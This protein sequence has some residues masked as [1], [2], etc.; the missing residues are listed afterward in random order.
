M[1]SFAD[2]LRQLRHERGLTQEQLAE[3]LDI[4]AASIRRLEVTESLPRKERLVLLSNFFNVSIDYLMGNTDQRNELVYH[5]ESD[6][7]PHVVNEP[8]YEYQT[9]PLLER[10][11]FD[12]FL[13]ATKEEKE[14]IIA[15]WHDEVKKRRKKPPKE[16]DNTPS[17]WDLKDK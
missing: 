12:D 4:P 8:S 11:F 16:E 1:P 5:K 7:T 17:A 9:F 2:R 14:Q 10:I 15:Y 6:G 13:E 3:Q